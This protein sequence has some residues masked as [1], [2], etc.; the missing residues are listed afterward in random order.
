MDHHC[1]WI[2]NCVGAKNQKLFIVFLSYA[3]V[4]CLDILGMKVLGFSIFLFTPF[5]DP[6]TA[7]VRFSH[8][9]LSST[10]WPFFTA[11]N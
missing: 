1:I 5:E 4:Y 10:S 9:N 8:P 11:S 7:E 2:D 3:L 6:A